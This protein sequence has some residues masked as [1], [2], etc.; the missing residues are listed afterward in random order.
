MGNGADGGDEEADALNEN[1]FDKEAAKALA[2]F[3]D[4]FCGSLMSSGELDSMSGFPGL[5]RSHRMVLK[6]DELS[7]PVW[8]RVV[9]LP[10]STNAEDEGEDESAPLGGFRVS[11]NLLSCF[12][13]LNATV[14]DGKY[15]LVATSRLNLPSD[16]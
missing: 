10:C 7:T 6:S 5:L 4:D 1:G 2:R 11:F 13:K 15:G 3:E 16:Q 8:S 14:D 9:S 12:K